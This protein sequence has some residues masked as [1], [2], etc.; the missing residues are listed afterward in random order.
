MPR[1]R[2]KK[3]ESL[4]HN[5]VATFILQDL[6]DPRIGFVTVT[7][8]EV[9][10]DLSRATVSLSVLGEPAQQRTTMRGIDAAKGQIRTRVGAT[11]SIR[12][13]PE[14]IFKLDESVEKSIHM[15][16]LIDAARQGDSDHTAPTDGES[17]E[18]AEED[19]AADSE[20]SAD[21]DADTDADTDAGADADADADADS[22]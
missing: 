2:I 5:E 17:P 13:V 4:I 14:L 7:N 15:N 20:D 6:Q 3:V 11:L 12:R 21:A 10:N 1:L 18:A 22:D 16:D 8:V 9:V 19:E